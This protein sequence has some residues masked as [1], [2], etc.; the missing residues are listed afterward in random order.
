L[1]LS[2]YLSV[3]TLDHS[4]V[5]FLECPKLEVLHSAFSDL[6]TRCGTGDEMMRI[7][8]QMIKEKVSAML[9]KCI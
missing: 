2:S 9:R 3:W 8:W 4:S 7:I 5:Y 1:G 6:C